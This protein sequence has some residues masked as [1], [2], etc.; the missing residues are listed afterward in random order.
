MSRSVESAG[1]SAPRHKIYV[2]IS[3]ELLPGIDAI[4]AQNKR[5]RNAQLEVWIEEGYGRDRPK[6]GKGASAK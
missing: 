3:S 6:N 4:A 5:T 2:R 1:G